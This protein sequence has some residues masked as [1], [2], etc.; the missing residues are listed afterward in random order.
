[1]MPSKIAMIN[2]AAIALHY[3]LLLLLYYFV[4]KVFKALLAQLREKPAQRRAILLA[5]VA[6]SL[7]GW[8][9]SFSLQ[10]DA[11]SIG[12]SARNDLVIDDGFVS[13][14]HACIICRHDGV[15]LEDLESTNKT[16]LNG[17]AVRD[18]ARLNEGDHIAIGPVTFEF[19]RG[20]AK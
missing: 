6:G 19:R 18:A 7:P 14:E 8:P 13:A 12:R 15:W 2:W 11:I 10:G 5:V 1:M 17:K 16:Y 9:P 3:G 4:Y 20:E